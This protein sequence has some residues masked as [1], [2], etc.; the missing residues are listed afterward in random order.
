M[1]PLEQ[2]PEIP[3]NPTIEQSKASEV[4]SFYAVYSEAEMN[5]VLNQGDLV[6]YFQM[7]NTNSAATMGGVQEVP[8]DIQP[9]ENEKQTDLSVDFVDYMNTRRLEQ[10]LSA[11]VWSDSMAN[12]ALERAE[13][14]VADFSHNGTRNCAGENLTMINSSNVAD[15]YDT[16]YSSEVHKLNMLDATYHS[17]AAASCQVGNTNYVVVL[18]GF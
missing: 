17:A 13:E 11:Y 12:T 9:S 1:A 8:E 18:F 2:E 7:L 4:G 3:N 14:I 16:F 6:T 5:E 10:G 15:W